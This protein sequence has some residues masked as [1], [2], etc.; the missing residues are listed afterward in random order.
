MPLW[1]FPS[2]SSSICQGRWKGG[3]KS[4]KKYRA[5]NTAI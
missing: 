5:T 4:T 2:C 1:F 3:G